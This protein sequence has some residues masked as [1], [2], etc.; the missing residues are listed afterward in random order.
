MK[1]TKRSLPLIMKN[2]R[3]VK[4]NRALD[5]IRFLF[6]LENGKILKLHVQC[7]L[8]IFNANNELIVCTPDLFYESA[9]KKRSKTLF[10][11][12]IEANKELLMSAPVTSFK[13]YGNNDIKI[14]FSS[15]A[16]MEILTSTTKSDDPDYSEDYRIFYDGDIDHQYSYPFGLS[17]N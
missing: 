14:S 5:L 3:I 2:A 6:E 12:S 11:D 4:I 13:F 9:T 10:D 7:F 1:I 16:H 15:G 17:D 8:R